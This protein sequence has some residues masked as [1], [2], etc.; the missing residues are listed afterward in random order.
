MFTGSDARYLAEQNHNRLQEIIIMVEEIA[1]KG[2]LILVIHNEPI[3][4]TLINM[5]RGL[6]Y[7]VTC[8]VNTHENTIQK[9]IIGW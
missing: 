6:N 4:P 2:E 5:L 3:D 8:E 7:R 9:L 1:L